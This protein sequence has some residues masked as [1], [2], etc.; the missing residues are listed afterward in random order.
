MTNF[1]DG[2][3]F[4]LHT[5]VDLEDAKLAEKVIHLML[6]GPKFL[7][8][9]RFGHLHPIDQKVDAKNIDPM[10]DLWMGKQLKS[11]QSE[12][13]KEGLLLLEFCREGDFMINW[14]KGD[15]PP[16]AKPNF[17]SISGG[18]P[19]KYVSKPE[20]RLAEYLD[21]IKQLTEILDPVFGIVQ[22]MMTPQWDVTYDLNIRLPDI[23]WG[24]IFGKPYIEF[25]G[26]EKLLNAPFFE[27]EKLSS[28]HIFAQLSESILEPELSKSKRDQLRTFL[29]SDCF[30]EGK[31]SYRHYKDGN[32]PDFK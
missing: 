2:L 29:G 9:K 24:S 19:I 10:V 14:T 15:N 26:H 6:D 17:N 7:K 23:Q 20:S 16:F 11:S 3:S 21:I 31:K 13:Y 4:S 27:V 18:I 12:A 8:P 30:M 25:F 1:I 22:N 32:A 28:G 5:K